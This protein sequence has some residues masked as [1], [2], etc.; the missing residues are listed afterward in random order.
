M[1][2]KICFISNYAYRLF[3]P[4]SRI[5]FGGIE[6]LFYLAAQ[7]LSGDKRFAVSFLMEDD[8]H[9]VLKE[10]VIDG[11]KLFKTSRQFQP[12]VYQDNQVE[13][14][15]RWFTYWAGKFN[16]LWQWPHLDFFRLWERLKAIKAD[17]YI[18]GSPGYESNLITF[19]TKIIRKKSMYLVANDEIFTESRNDFCLKHADILWSLSSRHRDRLINKF[20]RRTFLLPCWY[21]HPGNILPRQNR[22]Y[23]LWA[24]RIEPRKA[25]EIFLQIAKLLP[26]YKFV[27]IAAQTPR[28]KDLYRRIYRK[29]KS[30]KNITIKTNLNLVE[31][32]QLYQTA[33]AF[34]DTSRYNHLNLTQVQ[35]AAS[36][37]PNLSFFIDP[38]SSLKEYRWGYSAG[39]KLKQ[40]LINIKRLAS[41]KNLWQQLSKNAGTFAKKVHS[42][43]KNVAELKNILCEL[44]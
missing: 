41:D 11:I 24:G 12:L 44:S 14:Y 5:V 19:I 3:N 25:P 21:P 32:N 10:E 31:L 26:Q 4:K 38:H 39:G 17:I 37:L 22:K 36:C 7:G 18:F 43:N 27:M 28:D 40:M 35:A 13:K 20:N 30:L 42:S 23:F 2:L 9:T 29:A 34:I 16:Q 15:H 1:P 33:I 8:V 6:V